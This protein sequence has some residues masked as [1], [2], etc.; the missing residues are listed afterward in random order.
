MA[1]YSGRHTSGCSTDYYIIPGIY[2]L[3]V[4]ITNLVTFPHGGV[5]CRTLGLGIF[6]DL[7]IYI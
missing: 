5:R 2:D 4:S 7:Y 6:P 1:G 3:E